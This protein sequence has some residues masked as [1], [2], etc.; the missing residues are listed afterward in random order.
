MHDRRIHL[1]SRH[2]ER[3]LFKLSF[4][5]QATQHL[6]QLMHLDRFQGCWPHTA[7]I[8]F[9][10]LTLQPVGW[11]IHISFFFYPTLKSQKEENSGLLITDFLS[12]LSK[13]MQRACYQQDMLGLQIHSK[14]VC[15][16]KIKA[17]EFLYIVSCT[18]FCC[19]IAI[20]CITNRSC[21]SQVWAGHWWAFRGTYWV[22]FSQKGGLFSFRNQR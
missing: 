12:L 19:S 14:G 5:F 22:T 10:G 18:V 17:P 1:S 21:L 8:N 7:H 9:M 11:I 4:A 16:T 3:S 6:P 20:C 2:Q 15:S 13:N